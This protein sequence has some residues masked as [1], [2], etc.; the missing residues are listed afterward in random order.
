MP[1]NLEGDFLKAV[2]K[3]N[4]K[5]KRIAA[6]KVGIALLALTLTTGLAYLLSQGESSFQIG[7]MSLNS[8]TLFLSI[9]GLLLLSSS[10]IYFISIQKKSKHSLRSQPA[11][12]RSSLSPI[13]RLQS[14]KPKY[15]LG[16]SLLLFAL[17]YQT[18]P[19][20][21]NTPFQDLLT[22]A[23]Y[24]P[25]PPSL[26]SPWSWD[27]EKIHPII[28]HLPAEAEKS[29]KSVAEYIAQREP[30]PYLRV[31]ALHDYV[32]SRVTYD[33]DVLKTGKRSAQDAQT[34]FVTGKA[35]CE[36]YANLFMALGQSIGM[37]V[38][39]VGGKVRQDLAPIDVIPTP[40]R[41]I[42]SNYDWTLHAW[43][44][45]KVAGDWQLVDTTWDDSDANDPNATYE[46]DYLMPPPEVMITSHLPEQSAWQL[47]RHPK[48]QDSF[49][50]QLLLKPQFF[51]EKLVMIS[52]LEYSTSAK[53]IGVIEIKQP[54]NY[55]KKLAAVFAKRKESGF[56]LWSL[57]EGNPFNQEAKAD[58][59][60]CQSQN[61]SQRMVQISCN[62][63]ESG[64]YQVLL[65][66][67]EPESDSNRAK[68]TPIGQFRFR[69]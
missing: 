12:S 55:S 23:R 10:V 16:Y 64:D 36:G 62:F 58:L 30:N 24:R 44:A 21:L 13:D 40:L 54:P 5:N 59:K 11:K 52:P 45:V 63:A 25:A 60:L 26:S 22:R 66:S 4:R 38:V 2:R 20:L 6:Q 9:I 35:V 50:R 42:K 19:S 28:A 32:I 14:I 18:N 34:V 57:P 17:I 7:S 48:D 37:D 65:F 27:Q 67:L 56:S 46:A 49:E 39:F 8:R 53:T 51:M 47:L 29:I 41:L 69:A 68:P 31:K 1:K 3:L 43:N 61:K 15:F 33:L